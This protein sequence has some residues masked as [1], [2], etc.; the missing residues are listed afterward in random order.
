MASSRNAWFQ[1]LMAIGIPT[2]AFVLPRL[3]FSAFKTVAIILSVSVALVPV[4]IVVSPGPKT[5]G[6]VERLKSHF[7]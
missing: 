7:R 1:W 2:A 5:K 4:V 3:G 6:F